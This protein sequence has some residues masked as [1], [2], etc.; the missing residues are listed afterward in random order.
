[1]QMIMKHDPANF[2][3][4]MTVR[5]SSWHSEISANTKFLTYCCVSI[6]D[7]ISINIST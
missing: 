1:M 4:T 6:Y 3:R 7:D 5:D 2:T